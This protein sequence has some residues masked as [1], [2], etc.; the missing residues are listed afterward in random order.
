[1]L[2]RVPASALSPVEMSNQARPDTLSPRERLIAVRNR[3]ETPVLVRGSD[4]M[5]ETFESVRRALGLDVRP[6]RLTTTFEGLEV[7]PS[8]DAW[9]LLVGEEGPMRIFKLAFDHLVVKTLTGKE[10]FVGP[11]TIDH[12]ALKQQPRCRPRRS[13]SSGSRLRTSKAF[14]A[15]HS[16]RDVAL[17]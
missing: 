8:D 14:R 12:T 4:S 9:P 10:L 13:L 16:V 5:S 11:W 7:E 2:L 1:M 6:F 17:I 3:D 15:L